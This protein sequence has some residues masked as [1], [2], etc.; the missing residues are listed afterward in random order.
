LI[1]DEVVTGFRVHPGGAQAYFD[2]RADLATYGKVAGGG[3]PIGIVAGSSKFMDAI[4]GGYWQYG[5]QSFPEVG[6]TF[7]AGTYVRHPLNLAATKAVLKY[8]GDQGSNLQKSLNQKTESVAQGLNAFIDQRQA[9]IELGQFSSF[10]YPSFPHGI[11]YGSL[12]FYL[13]REKGVHIWEHRPCFLTTAHDEADIRLIVE[14]FKQSV[15][16]MQ[17]ADLLPIGGDMPQ[18]SKGLAESNFS[19]TAVRETKEPVPPVPGAKLGRDPKGDPAWFAPDPERP[20]KYLQVG[21]VS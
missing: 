9:P 6:V 21:S 3:Y 7:F 5:D 1:F 13:M 15:L 10:F 11:A 18:D 2:I 17:D 20:G 19:S 12:L 4:D 14:A 16:E 8:L